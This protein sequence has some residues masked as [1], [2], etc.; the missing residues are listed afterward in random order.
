MTDLEKLWD[1]L[2]TRKPPVTDILREARVEAARRR[3]RQRL[4]VRPLVGAAAAVALVGAFVAGGSVD[5]PGT[6]T[7]DLRPAAFQADLSPAA[8]CEDLLDSYRERGLEQVTKDGW[9]KDEIIPLNLQLGDTAMGPMVPAAAGEFFRTSGEA[10]HKTVGT[11][12]NTQEVGVDEPDTLKTDGTRLVRMRGNYL[13]TYD[14]SGKEILKRSSLRLPDFRDGSFLLRGDEVVAVGTD[15]RSRDLSGSRVIVVSLADDAEPS[16]TSTT[17]YS[18]RIV[19]TR[20]HGDVVRLVMS[21]GLP[22]LDFERSTSVDGAKVLTANRKAVRE[23]TLEDWLPT[24]TQKGKKKQQLLDCS[25]VALPPAGLGLDTTSIVSFDVGKPA[26][27]HAIGL[28]GAAGIAYE[29]DGHLYLAAPPTSYEGGVTHLFDF[30]I[31]GVRTTHVASGEVPGVVQDR[32]SLDEADDVLRVAVGPSGVTD[33]ASAVVTFER[34]GEALVER[35]RLD[36]LGRGED[37]KSVRW[38][39]DLAVLVTFQVTDPL[40]TVDLSDTAKPRLLGSLEV[41]GF[42]A[43][44]HPLEKDRL[45]GVGYGGGGAQLSLFDLS[46]RSDVRERD[47]TSFRGWRPLVDGETRAFTWLPEKKTVLTVLQRGRA[48]S[49]A[50]VKVGDGSLTGKLSRLGD[51]NPARVRTVGLAD[52]RVAIVSGKVT[53]FLPLD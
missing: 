17:T 51:V 47:T 45:L 32:W 13:V 41:P 19:S 37:L 14:T 28:A 25:D 42:S 29:S 24:F 36:G 10:L 27:Q 38:F 6:S 20:Q 50:Q 52:G 53:R 44:L 31:D 18:S 4:V 12:T 8:S 9:R 39:D 35:G 21:S 1:D 7:D 15:A 34:E 3:R 2:P 33:F 46:D 5:G 40:Y 16:I 49:V 48:V 30:E 11:G 23:S 43:Y 22:D 26:T